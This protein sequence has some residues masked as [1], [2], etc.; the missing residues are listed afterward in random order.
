[1]IVATIAAYVIA[2][3]AVLLL[4]VKFLWLF[5]ILFAYRTYSSFIS[6]EWFKKIGIENHFIYFIIILVLSIVTYLLVLRLT[7]DLIWI[8]YVLL[9]LMAIWV[10]KNYQITDILFFKDFFQSKGMWNIDFWTN[11]MKQ[12]FG[13]DRDSYASLFSD[14]FE[15]VFGVTEK[16]FG[17]L[18]DVF[19]SK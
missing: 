19:K 12:I 14:A 17:G 1:M 7:V 16:L 9:A 3:L 13:T 5:F 8:R 4:S 6:F 10:F 18:S 15:N 11:Q 2:I